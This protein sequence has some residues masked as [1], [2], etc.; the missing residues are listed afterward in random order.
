MQI[1]RQFFFSFLQRYK[2][3]FRFDAEHNKNLFLYSCDRLLLSWDYE[4]EY[5]FTRAPISE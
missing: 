5:R 3:E 4:Y 2:T 1:L